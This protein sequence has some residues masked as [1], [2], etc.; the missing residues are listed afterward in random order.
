M[1]TRHLSPDEFATY[2]IGEAMRRK[3]AAGTDGYGPLGM[4]LNLL[5]RWV[6]R[7]LLASELKAVQSAVPAF[8]LDDI[9]LTEVE[10]P[11]RP[12]SSPAP[13]AA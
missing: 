7:S 11:T 3:I 8:H 12:E 13:P 4:E 1:T 10:A 2:L 9:I 5:R 6:V